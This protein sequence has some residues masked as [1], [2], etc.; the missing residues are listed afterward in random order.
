[1]NSVRNSGMGEEYQSIPKLIG[2]FLAESLQVI[3][4]PQ[5]I[6]Y[7]KVN[8]FFLQRPALDLEDIPMFYSLSNSGEYFEREVDWL[9]DIMIAGVH[10][11][12]TVDHSRWC[13]Q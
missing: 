9:L 4:N 7:E 1:M 5:H 11:D 3:M 2:V 13:L 8:T 6:L 10:N 12:E